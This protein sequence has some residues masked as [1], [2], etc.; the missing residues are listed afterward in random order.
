MVESFYDEEFRTWLAEGEQNPKQRTVRGL[1]N[2][3]LVEV[4][5]MFSNPA[6]HPPFA[7]LLEL[8]DSKGSDS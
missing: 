7:K 4:I 6:V 1:N 8:D 3:R 5:A 2:D